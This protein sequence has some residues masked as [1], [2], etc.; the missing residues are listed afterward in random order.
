ME[1]KQH[2]FSTYSKVVCITFQYTLKTGADIKAYFSAS[3]TACYSAPN[4]NG[5]LPCKIS[6]RGAAILANP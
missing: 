5:F 6:E 4:L 1:P 2:R 3:K